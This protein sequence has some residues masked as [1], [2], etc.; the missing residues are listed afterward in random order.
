MAVSARRTRRNAAT[1]VR[2]GEVEGPLSA[3]ILDW[4]YQ[5]CYRG[6]VSTTLHVPDPAWEARLER[7]PLPGAALFGSRT[8][9]E[10]LGLLTLHPD[11]RFNARDLVFQLGTTLESTQRAMER[12]LTAE[13]V[14]EVRAGRRRDIVMARDAGTMALRQLAL[15]T[16]TLAPRLRWAWEELGPG[17]V[18]ASFVHGSIA[19]GTETATS[20]LDVIVVGD[21]AIPDLAPYLADLEHLAGRPVN[22][23][24]FSSDA[25][26]GGVAEPDGFLRRVVERP[27]LLVG[28]GDDWLFSTETDARRVA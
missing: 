7:S 23:L 10:V 14:S 22:A 6:S 19:A 26:A 28:V 12:L 17:A 16:V 27:R 21:A 11:R 4:V 9:A 18:V 2:R 25:Y 5:S 8:I 1:E 3:P 15:A 24:C 20:D 13:V